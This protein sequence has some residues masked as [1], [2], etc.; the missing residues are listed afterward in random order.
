MSIVCGSV[1]SW[2]PKNIV[3]GEGGLHNPINRT[4]CLKPFNLKQTQEILIGMGIK[5]SATQLAELY[6]LFG[7]APYYISLLKKNKSIQQ[8]IESLLFVENGKLV[9]EYQNLLPSLFENANNHLEVL[10]PMAIKWKGLSRG[11]LTT[12]YGAA[13]PLKIYAS[14]IYNKLQPN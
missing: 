7:D 10:D 3:N 6:M 13:M 1:A 4:I 8:N 5:T 11:E 12:D 14:F 2:M 9:N